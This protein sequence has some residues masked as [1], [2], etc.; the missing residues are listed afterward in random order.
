M[1]TS[2]CLISAIGNRFEQILKTEITRKHALKR[3][4]IVEL[5]I[6]IISNYLKNTGEYHIY[7]AN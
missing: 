2:N 3:N 1:D 4:Y 7:N 6:I 5:R